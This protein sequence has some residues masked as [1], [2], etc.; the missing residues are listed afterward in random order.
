MFSLRSGRQCVRA[1]GA[2]LPPP[3]LPTSPAM[4]TYLITYDLAAPAA[5]P[6]QR[7]HAAR[8]GLGPPARGHL[9][10]AVDERADALERGS[11]R[12]SKARTAC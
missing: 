1:A 7:H 2:T 12:S 9:V 3:S 4:R 10:R 8:R 6:S 5:T 11:S